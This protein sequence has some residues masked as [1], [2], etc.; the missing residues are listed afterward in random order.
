MMLF[1][2]VLTGCNQ[3]ES[4]GQNQEYSQCL[5]DGL[6]YY[7]QIGSYP[8]LTTGERAEIKIERVCR[9]NVKMFRLF[10]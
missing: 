3:N 9:K 10:E 2:V 4:S 6:K 5:V 8:R 1:T 7:K